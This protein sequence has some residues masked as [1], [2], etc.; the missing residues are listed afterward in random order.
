MDPHM[1]EVVVTVV[2]SVIASSGFWAFVQHMLNKHDSS[3][4]LLL[5][6]AHDRIMDLGKHYLNRKKGISVEEY[7][8]LVTYL[9]EPYLKCGGNGSAKMVMD[10]VL[11]LEVKNSED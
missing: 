7:E 5:G 10:K 1:I 11:Q 2:C 4:Q 6:L 8:N 9:Y 3:T